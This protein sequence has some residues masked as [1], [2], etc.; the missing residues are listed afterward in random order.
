MQ[1]GYYWVFIPSSNSPNW[2]IGHYDS[3]YRIVIVCGQLDTYD[4]G[5]VVFGERVVRS[6]R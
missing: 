2:Q 6:V 1:S 4:V 5:N 3:E